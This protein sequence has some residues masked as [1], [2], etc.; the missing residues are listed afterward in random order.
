M[1]IGCWEI[2]ETFEEM[3]EKKMHDKVFPTIRYAQNCWISREEKMGIGKQRIVQNQ[4]YSPS[5]I[6]KNG[7]PLPQNSFRA[8]R[9]SWNWAC[10]VSLFA[11]L[12]GHGIF[13]R[14]TQQKWGY[15]WELASNQTWLV[16]IIYPNSDFEGATMN[17]EVIWTIMGCWYTD[18]KTSSPAP[19]GAFFWIER[20]VWPSAL[21]ELCHG[22]KNLM[23]WWA[24]AKMG[25]IIP[26][27][28]EKTTCLKPHVWNHMFETT[29]QKTSKIRSSKWN[30]PPSHPTIAP[31]G[32]PGSSGGCQL[33]FLCSSSTF[34]RSEHTSGW[35]DWA[36]AGR[37]FWAVSAPVCEVENPP[38]SR[39]SHELV[40]R[41]LIPGY[42]KIGPL[43]VFQTLCHSTHSMMV[44]NGIPTF[45][46]L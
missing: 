21:S 31:L 20:R 17:C 42:R 10:K 11:E 14:F 43:W 26:Y 16:K 9:S 32:F 23:F 18:S 13:M 35:L 24:T 34:T 1:F 38:I 28:V 7:T 5:F 29:N 22:M 41:F 6:T 19:I 39:Q 27:I 2:K 12:A 3:I 45:H 40:S 15:Q 44:E 33:N 37:I 4:F 8:C 46:G 30:L 36:P 25:R